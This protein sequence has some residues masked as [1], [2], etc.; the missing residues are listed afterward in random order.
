MTI[1]VRHRLFRAILSC[2]TCRVA[3]AVGPAC[4]YEPLAAYELGRADCASNA[5]PLHL[6]VCG[7][8][9]LE[10]SVEEVANNPPP[11]RGLVAA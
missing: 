8:G 6:G 1:L 4:A 11:P 5:G 3:V 9:N 10:V 7:G 2:T